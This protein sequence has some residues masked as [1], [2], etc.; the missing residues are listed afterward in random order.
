VGFAG[1]DD[2]DIVM[3]IKDVERRKENFF[4]EKKRKEEIF[5]YICTLLKF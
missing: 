5:I 4:L 3:M 1:D 2:V